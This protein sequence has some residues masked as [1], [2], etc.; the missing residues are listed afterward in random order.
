[1]TCGQTVTCVE[2]GSKV[3]F[4]DTQFLAKHIRANPNMWL[5]LISKWNELVKTRI[6]CTLFGHKAVWGTQLEKSQ[7]DKEM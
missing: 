2:E 3:V 6:E 4:I 7:A 1:M 5:G